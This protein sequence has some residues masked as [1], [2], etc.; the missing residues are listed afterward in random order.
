MAKIPQKGAATA[1]VTR[2]G[3]GY[4]LEIA[5]TLLRERPASSLV[6]QL[7]EL[8]ERGGSAIGDAYA[9]IAGHVLVGVEWLE[10]FAAARKE[11][12]LAPGP[13]KVLPSRK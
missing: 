10:D 6:V 2:S 13:A 4:E 8:R 11:R 1:P 9:V 12:R 5:P 3:P 7:E